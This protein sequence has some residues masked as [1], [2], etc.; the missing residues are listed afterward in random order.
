[1]SG[2]MSGVWKRSQGRTSEAPPDE[3]GGNRYVRPTATAPHSDSTGERPAASRILESCTYG[4][5]KSDLGAYRSYPH[6]RTIPQARSYQA[7]LTRDRPLQVVINRKSLLTFALISPFF[8]VFA[9]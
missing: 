5:G 6:T 4:V 8:L 3:R 9:F 2:S 1:M 7:P